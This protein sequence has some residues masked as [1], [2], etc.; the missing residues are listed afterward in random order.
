MLKIIP[1]RDFC[2]ML[3]EMQEKQFKQIWKCILNLIEN[4][5]PHDSKKI[6]EYEECPIYRVDSGEFRIIYQ[7]NEK[8]L[9]PLVLGKRNDGQVYKEMKRKLS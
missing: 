2:N 4:P 7:Y 9:Y 8:C 6:G 3:N 1:T 5:R